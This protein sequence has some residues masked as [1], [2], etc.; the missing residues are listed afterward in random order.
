MDEGGGGNLKAL[1]WT[2]CNKFQSDK[3]KHL[4]PFWLQIYFDQPGNYLTKQRLVKWY[5][6]WF[7]LLSY[8][9]YFY[10]EVKIKSIV[11]DY[12]KHSYIK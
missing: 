7:I 8:T 4:K 2:A 3:K 10:N 12:I 6:N 1:Q 11:N 9:R 5:D